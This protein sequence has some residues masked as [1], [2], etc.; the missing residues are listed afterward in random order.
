MF[1][2]YIKA[3]HNKIISVLHCVPMK[4]AFVSEG[5]CVAFAQFRFKRTICGLL[6]ASSDIFLYFFHA[7]SGHSDPFSFDPFPEVDQSQVYRHIPI[8]E[9]VICCPAVEEQLTGIKFLWSPFQGSYLVIPDM[10]Y[11]VLFPHE[12]HGTGE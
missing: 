5:T 3:V 8:P 2:F 6:C 7:S 4:G 9:S 12:V 1:L 10:N 11:I